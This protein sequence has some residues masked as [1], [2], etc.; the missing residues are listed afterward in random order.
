[1]PEAAKEDRADL[2]EYAYVPSGRSP[3]FDLAAVTRILGPLDRNALWQIITTIINDRNAPH[4]QRDT[5]FALLEKIDPQLRPLFVTFAAEAVAAGGLGQ[6]RRWKSRD[7]VNFI[8]VG[9]FDLWRKTLHVT[10]PGVSAEARTRFEEHLNLVTFATVAGGQP[11][12][13]C[14]ILRSYGIK[15]PERPLPDWL[16]VM[17]GYA[18]EGKTEGVVRLEPDILGELFVLERWAGEFSV[19]SNTGA[20]QAQTQRLMD[21]AFA[22]KHHQTIDFFKRCLD[23]FPDHPSLG[24]IADI[25]IP[26]GDQAAYGF[27]MD[28][29]VN[30]GH[31]GGI[32]SDAGRTDLSKQCFSQILKQGRCLSRSETAPFQSHYHESLAAALNNLAIAAVEQGDVEAATR[33]FDEAIALLDA[34]ASAASGDHY[35]RYQFADL[36]ASVLRN[37]AQCRARGDDIPGAFA[38]LARILDDPD[39][40][41]RLRAEALLVRAG[42]H[43]RRE[44]DEAALA[45]YEGILGLSGPNLAE[46]KELAT[47]RLIAPLAIGAARASEGGNEA[48][49]LERLDRLVTLTADRPDVR[50]M[51]L[52]NRSAVRWK[53]GDH[54]GAVDDCTAVLEDPL[55][56]PTQ[57]LKSL[58]NRGQFFLAQRRLDLAQD[59]VDSVLATEDATARDR[60]HAL[61]TRAQIRYVTGN[62]AG[63]LADVAAITDDPAVDTEVRQAAEGLRARWSPE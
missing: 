22:E 61:L 54:A 8:L 49:A 21:V 53:K 37:R 13:V 30:M 63:A 33:D 4:I 46:Q 20:S 40:F 41:D 28:Y 31:V 1:M 27:F 5:M 19:D 17:T 55:S 34:V 44:D 25:Q 57:R 10:T 45:D 60:L 39:V 58:L 47:K 3:A 11:E 12:K 50:A 36:L 14:E 62:P 59:D 6:L 23:D 15:A 29:S 18:P 16:R 51:A 56:P 32:L 35:E 52:V 2:F 42:L 24:R 9:E 26:E 48:A 7:L 38:D 43:F